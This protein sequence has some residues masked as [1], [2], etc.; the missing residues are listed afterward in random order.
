LQ[1]APGDRIEVDA[2]PDTLQPRVAIAVRIHRAAGGVDSFTATAA[3][4]TRLETELLRQGGVIPYIL[5]QTITQK[6]RS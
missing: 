3:V 4:E 5:E 2:A 1:I 6:D